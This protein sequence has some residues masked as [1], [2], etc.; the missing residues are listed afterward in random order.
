MRR[1]T[2]LTLILAAAVAACGSSATTASASGAAQTP[3]QSP[4][5]SPAAGTPVAGSLAPASPVPASPVPASPWASSAPP[6]PAGADTAGTVWLCRP[7]IADNPCLGDLS[8]TLVDSLGG[9]TVEPKAPAIER[10]IDCFYV[11]PTVSQQHAVNADLSIE[12]D[13]LSVARYQV[14]LF[15]QV[16]NVY[17]PIYPQLT[18]NASSWGGI[19]LA[20]IQI[21]YGGVHAAFTDYMANY[22]HGRGI[23]FIGH[24]QGAEVLTGLIH[25]VVDPRPE[26]RKQL[27]SAFLIGGNVTVPVGKDVGGDFATIPA[28]RSTSQTGCLVAYSSFDSTPPAGAVF[29][30]PSRLSM[31]SFG[32]GPQQVLCVNPALP[33]GGPAPLKTYFETAYVV[34]MGVAPSPTPATHYVAYAGELTGECRIQDGAAWLQITRSGGG[35]TMSA[36]LGDG[37]STWG[38]HLHDISLTMGNLIDLVRTQAAAYLG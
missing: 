15:S 28:C 4:S 12:V 21:A 37:G 1:L 36:L 8:V 32:T 29:G 2:P 34:R 17:A 10:P 26:V 14:A 9:Q 20:N 7:G 16:C 25:N 22:N 24:S 11:Y 13:E 5:G 18:V 33:K 19:T 30:R 31:F 27:V 35:A 38:L 23:V 3:G 6:S